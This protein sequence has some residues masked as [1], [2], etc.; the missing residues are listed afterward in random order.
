MGRLGRTQPAHSNAPIKDESQ[1]FLRKQSLEGPNPACRIV[2]SNP[3][4]YAPG[5]KNWTPLATSSY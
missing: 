3:T 5:G 1:S 4:L 2:G